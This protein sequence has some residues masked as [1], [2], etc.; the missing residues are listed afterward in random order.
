[1]TWNTGTSPNLGVLQ[2]S[3]PDE[4][5][6]QEG[7]RRAGRRVSEVMDEVEDVP[8]ELKRNP[9]ERTTSADVA[10]KSGATVIERDIFPLKSGEGGSCC[11]KRARSS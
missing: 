4:F 10:E 7:H 6:L 9:R 1:M 8:M 5:L 2:D 3:V 11:C